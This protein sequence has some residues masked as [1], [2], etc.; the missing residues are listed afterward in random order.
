MSLRGAGLPALAREPVLLPS[1]ALLPQ[2][3]ATLRAR[4][5]WHRAA[6]TAFLLPVTQ[7]TRSLPWL[8]TTPLSSQQHRGA[9]S[10]NLQGGSFWVSPAE[11]SRGSASTLGTRCRRRRQQGWLCLRSSTALIIPWHGRPLA[12]TAVGS[13]QHPHAPASTSKLT[14]SV[15]AFVNAMEGHFLGP[16]CPATC[17]G[18]STVP[19]L[20]A[21]TAA[22]LCFS[23]GA[24]SAAPTGP[25]SF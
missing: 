19:W 23:L 6:P 4:E 10:C 12:G 14:G 9:A 15:S 22:E 16:F 25:D 20:G 18:S 17:V 8:R 21:D 13:W 24:A 5:Q 2:L 1:R 3:C 7:Q 11:G